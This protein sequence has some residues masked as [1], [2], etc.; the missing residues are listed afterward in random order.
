ML[1]NT[2][3]TRLSGITLTNGW[4]VGKILAVG[5][6]Q[7][8]DEG[9]GGTFSV[10]YVVSKDGK[11]AFLKAFDLD[12]VLKKRG[13]R[14]WMETLQQETTAFNNE[15][16]LNSFC[17]KS[18]MRQVV[19][20]IEH[21]EVMVPQ[22]P[23]DMVNE[24]PYMVMELADGGDVRSYIKQNNLHDLSIK[25][26]YLKEIALGISQLHAEKISHQD[27]KPS[28][29]MIFENSGAKIGDLGRASVQGSVGVYDGW[30][31]AGDHGYAPPEQLYGLTLNEWVDR[32]E[33]C[34]LYQFGS[35]ISFL[36][37][38]V[39]V[40]TIIQ[41]RIPKALSPKRWGGGQSTY[42]QALPYLQKAFYDGLEEFRTTHP[43][44]LGKRV[45]D[46]INQCSNPDYT[47][48]G[49][50][51]VMGKKNYLGLGFNRFVSELDYLSNEAERQSIIAAKRKA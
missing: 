37:F 45:V 39:N 51:G 24:I 29:V 26:R 41:R 34:D 48:R 11:T 18:K 9:S 7:E 40:N 43:E 47:M 23:G 16:G 19:R 46:L 50:K 38:G 13:T 20:I 21:G 1:D 33:R 28:N 44:W 22:V 2:P 49:A 12:N 30:I 14:S 4:T 5:R 35:M 32:R 25:F 6:A 27:I 15:K 3:A 36:I 31:V 8:G 10:S 42:A 17:V